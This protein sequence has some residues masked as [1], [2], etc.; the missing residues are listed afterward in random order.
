[1][2]DFRQASILILILA[3]ILHFTFVPRYQIDPT[4]LLQNGD[5]QNGFA[6]WEFRTDGGNRTGKTGVVTLENKNPSRTAFLH[7]KV[8]VPKG[9]LLMKFA[10]V[11]RTEGI[12]EGESSWHRARLS[13][14][15]RDTSGKSLWNYPH[16]IDIPLTTDGWQTFSQV[17]LVPSEAVEV[18]AGMEIIRATGTMHVQNMSL[19]S[20]KEHPWFTIAA[21]I[22]L[23]IWGVAFLWVGIILLRTF[24]SPVAKVALGVASGLIF[25]GVWMPAWMKNLALDI[26]QEKYSLFITYLSAVLTG[27]NSQH[28]IASYPLIPP[29]KFGHFILFSLLAFICRRGRPNGSIQVLLINLMLF[30]ATTEVLQF[31]AFSRSPRIVDWIIDVSGVLSGLALSMLFC[32]NKINESFLYGKKQ[33]NK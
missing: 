3:T 8:F 27:A 29:D 4:E 16:Q 30:A 1:M 14:V 18:V 6:S 9:P 32:K 33:E 20:A 5:F 12:V 10:G 23:F 17:F 26:V 28:Q 13:L 15:S 31:F 7:Q 11:V 21:N 25:F 24:Q 2:I 22:L 19:A